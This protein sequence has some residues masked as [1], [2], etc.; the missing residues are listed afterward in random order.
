MNDQ[1]CTI[2][3]VPLGEDM[4]KICIPLTGRT[5]EAL[6]RE[7]AALKDHPFDLIEWR[8]DFLTDLSE[9][10]EALDTLRDCL[11]DAPLLGTFRTAGEGGDM[12]LSEAEY[13]SVVRWMIHTGKLDA[14][15]LEYFHDE[16]ERDAL[17]D[18][19][20]AAGLTVI[21]SSHDFQKTPPQEEMTARLTAMGDHGCIAK[22]AVMP[23]SASDVAA[24][25]AATAAVRE[26][27]PERPV[28]TMAMGGLGAVSRI[29]GET[30]GSAL[31]FGTAG[32]SSAPG[33]LD[34]RALRQILDVL[35]RIK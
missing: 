28:I 11:P 30:F 23:Q 7:C 4:P 27:R 17:R 6:R 34:A 25:L 22:L 18:E 16:A 19:A 10:E 35:H 20:Q 33:Q 13:F 14:V 32:Q 26:A 29:A 21:M 5:A 24:L 9:R 31:T 15:D 12:P 1:T 2:R 3:G 8:A